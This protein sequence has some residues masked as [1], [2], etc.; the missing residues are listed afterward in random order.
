MEQIDLHI[1]TT[2]SDGTDTPEAVVQAAARLGLRA[3]AITDHDTTDGVERAQAAGAAAGIEVVRGIEISTDYEG[4]DV[5]ILGYFFRPDTK[6]PEDVT[7]WSRNERQ[8]R[9]LRMI[10]AM[11]TDGI[12]ISAEQLAE[13]HP[14]AVLGRPH[15]AQRLMELGMVGSVEEAFA[16][17]LSPGKKY[18]ASRRR[19]PMESAIEKIRQAG[20]VASAA[21]PLQYRFSDD[22][23]LRWLRTARDAGCGAME[24]FYSGYT[25]QQR[26]MLM[27]TARQLGFALSGG[28]DY[29]G[30]VKP[31]ISLG[32]GTDGTLAVPY[33]LLEK[34]RALCP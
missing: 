11:R 6:E 5:H 17:Y 33:E 18:Y 10:E 24:V 34:L 15:M 13:A 9:N 21:H 27:Q 19:I 29:H 22:D 16:K 2:A 26:E 20:G 12:D 8:A 30:T 25:P 3:I 4:R 14:G 7:Q 28:S 1:H 32:T 31:H 23:R